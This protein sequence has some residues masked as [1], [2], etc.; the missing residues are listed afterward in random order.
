[1]R[2]RRSHSDG[3]Q[4]GYH[5]DPEITGEECPQNVEVPGQLEA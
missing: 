2:D 5:R 4:G 3:C 1:M